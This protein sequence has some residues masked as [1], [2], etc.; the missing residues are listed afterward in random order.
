MIMPGNALLARA[1]INAPFLPVAA[2]ISAKRLTREHPTANPDR[3]LA[4]LASNITEA[5]ITETN[6]RP[7]GRQQAAALA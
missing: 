5:G 1:I 6:N 2:G 3:A 7:V 4:K